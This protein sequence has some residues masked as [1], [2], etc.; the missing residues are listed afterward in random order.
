[1]RFLLILVF[2]S[3]SC[4]HGQKLSTHKTIV[5]D[6]LYISFINEFQIPIEVR[7]S[8]LDSTKRHIETI[9]YALL[10]YNDTLKNAVALPIRKV[11][12]TSSIDLNK[13]TH[14]KGN[15]GHPDAQ[16]DETKYILPFVKGKKYKIMQS[17]GGSFSHNL[18]SSYYAI[19]FSLPIGDTIVAARDGLVFYVKQDSKEHCRTRKCMD[20][21]NKILIL[22]QDGTYANYV[23]LDYN[24]AFVNVGDQVQAGE[25]IGISGM[26]GFTTK[27]HL[28]FVVHKA[29]GISVPV[30]FE[31]VRR[32]KLKKGK[33]YKRRK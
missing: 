7:L 29:R 31:G 5:K 18:K 11:R 20:K 26:T 14:F 12:D 3:F 19:D 16:P 27:P 6:T 25:V 30:Y 22:H 4:L 13:F 8:P 2:F 23:H 24:G 32:K 21:A 33:F 28:H 9:N 1:M 17:F 10:D 15:F